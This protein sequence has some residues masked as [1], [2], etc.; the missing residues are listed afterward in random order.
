VKRRPRP[1]KRQRVKREP[2]V[3]RDRLR[4][5]RVFRID[6]EPGRPFVVE[7]RV[8]KHRRAMRDEINFHE[9][10]EAA[11]DTDRDCMGYVRSW[12]CPRTRRAARIRPRGT[13]A[14]MFLNVRD[15]RKRPSEIVAHECTHAA[16]AWARL[17]RARLGVMSGEEVLCYAV[18]RLVKQLNRAL[19]AHRVW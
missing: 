13:V 4:P 11:A 17:Q 8:A 10:P 2:T 16:M 6:P 7:V 19:Y 15:L 3:H 14:R 1:Q 5:C 18:G 12:W 9:G